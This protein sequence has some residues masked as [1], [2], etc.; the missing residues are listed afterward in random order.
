MTPKIRP[1]LATANYVASIVLFIPIALMIFAP[2]YPVSGD[3]HGGLLS[4]F[5]GLILL[6]VPVLFFAAG[7]AFKANHS[8][9]W[10]FQAISLLVLAAIIALVALL[11]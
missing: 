4:A 11:Q 7:R 6:P 1:H 8:R 5:G 10:L 9:A 2:L 3:R